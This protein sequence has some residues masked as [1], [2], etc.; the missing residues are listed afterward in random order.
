MHALNLFLL[1]AGTQ[2][3]SYLLDPRVMWYPSWVIYAV[4]LTI[5][6]V[7]VVRVV[8]QD[9]IWGVFTCLFVRPSSSTNFRE[10]MGIM[11]KTYWLL[12]LNYAII[13]SVFALLVIQRLALEWHP[14]YILAPMIIFLH[15]IVALMITSFFTGEW[16]RMRENIQVINMS[17]QLMGLVLIPLTIILL[18]NPAFFYQIAYVG[19]II[20]LVFYV[21]RLYRGG[22]YAIQN[23]IPWYYIILYLCSLEIIPLAVFYKLI[24]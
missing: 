6:L 1:Q 13:S 8:N 12:V 24:T 21:V 2:E 22:S 15:P 11:G 17:Y 3:G 5:A 16:R 7:G 19:A 18:L 14:L 10:T 9:L 23:N 20:F 4:V